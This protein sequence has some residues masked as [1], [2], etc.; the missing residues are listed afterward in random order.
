MATKKKVSGGSATIERRGLRRGGGENAFG[1]PENF[2]VV[3]GPNPGDMSAAALNKR[4]AGNLV[5]L[6]VIRGALDNQ[7]AAEP[8]PPY[9]WHSC[10]AGITEAIK[11][12]AIEDEDGEVL[13]IADGRHRKDAVIRVREE[14]AEIGD[15]VPID[16]PSLALR[17]PQGKSAEVAER[18][19]QI[20]RRCKINANIRVAMKPS[21]NAARAVEVSNGGAVSDY[22]VGCAIG[23]PP[24]TAERD[25]AALIALGMCCFEIQDAVDA[26]AIRIDQIAGWRNA[27]GELTKTPEEQRAW[28]AKRTAPRE[29]KPREKT[30]RQLTPKKFG[31]LRAEIPA[32]PLY[33]LASLIAGTMTIAEVESEDVRAAY[34]RAFPEAK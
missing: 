14:K 7:R 34:F 25:A 4:F 13:I 1:D 5:A 28:L 16:L 2:C 3:D 22:V 31:K 32:G 12:A 20:V 27:H 21:H 29:K 11:Y 18:A 19:Y 8:A 30:G 24:E 15:P 26:G 9:F 33:E 17:I 10:R 6:A 23:M